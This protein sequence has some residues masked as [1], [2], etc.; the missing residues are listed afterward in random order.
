MST[1]ESYSSPALL[2]ILTSVT[3]LSLSLYMSFFWPLYLLLFY[4]SAETNV[5]TLYSVVS[6]VGTKMPYLETRIEELYRSGDPSRKLTVQRFPPP[7]DK[8]LI[9]QCE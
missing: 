1:R 2:A 9:T 4:K 3:E 8:L 5:C 6:A 7:K